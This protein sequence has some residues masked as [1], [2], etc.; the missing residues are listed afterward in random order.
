M[1][2][3]KGWIF[4]SKASVTGT[5]KNLLSPFQNKNKKEN[6]FI[7]CNEPKLIKWDSLAWKV[8]SPHQHIPQ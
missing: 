5:Q 4:F 1:F 2:Y 8:N 3:R 6:I 7:F